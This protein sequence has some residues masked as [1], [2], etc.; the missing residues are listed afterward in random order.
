[1]TTIFNSGYCGSAVSASPGTAVSICTIKDLGQLKGATLFNKGLEL[2]IASFSKANSIIAVK[3]RKIHN[4]PEFWDVRQNNTKNSQVTSNIGIMS[5]SNSGQP[6]FELDF[7]KGTCFHKILAN[8]SGQDKWDLV[9]N[10]Q[11]GSLFFSNDALNALKGADMGMFEVEPIEFNIGSSG[12]QK[13]TVMCQIKDT[14]QFNKYFVFKTNEELGFNFAKLPG[15]LDCMV[16]V[17]TPVTGTTL[18][19]K[20]LAGCSGTPIDVLIATAGANWKVGGV[21]TT[22]K[23]VTN[24]VYNPTTED[25]TLTLSSALIVG[26]TVQPSLRD[27]I[28]DVAT[29]VTGQLYA[30]KSELLTVG[31]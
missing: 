2:P 27:G 18:T 28:Y 30:G 31:L 17:S 22:P 6:A 19:V 25:Y 11:T 20:V 7:D 24:A 9:L 29:D 10:F 14:E 23:T 21:Q 26:D 12:K 4:L 5:K 15:V 3:Q 8:L 1:M 13:S 16:V